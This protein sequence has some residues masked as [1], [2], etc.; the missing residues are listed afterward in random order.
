MNIIKH[1]T[2]T[3]FVLFVSSAIAADKDFDKV[4]GYF[5]KLQNEVSNKQLSKTDRANFISGFVKKELKPE[6]GRASCRERV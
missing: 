3:G 6:I 1:L 2:V 4:C 5:E